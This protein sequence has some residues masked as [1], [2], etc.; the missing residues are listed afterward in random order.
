MIFNMDP[1]QTAAVMH[2]EGPALVLAGP[3]SGKTTVITNRAVRIAANKCEPSR[4]LCVTFTNAAAEEMRQR[5]LKLAETTIQDFAP[6]ASDI[7][8]FYTVHAFCNNIISEYEKRTGVR[9]VRI[10][11]EDSPRNSIF[12]RIYKKYN[13]S[14]PDEA[15]LERIKGYL[16]RE[17]EGT[18][19]SGE[20]IQK[21]PSGKNQIRRFSDIVREYT[22]VKKENG[23]IDFDDMVLMSL[24]LLTVNE[25]IRGWA[26]GLFDYIQV[27]EAQDL[28]RA[29][30][31]VLR[32]IAGNANIFIVADDDQS[33]YGFRG[34]EP[35]CLFDFA[36]EYP[37]AARYELTR[38]F[39]ST[40]EIVKAS[41][42]LVS[43]NKKRFF[44]D[45][46]TTADNS[47]GSFCTVFPHDAKSQAMLC[48]QEALASINAGE[49]LAVL[50]RNGVSSLPVRAALT[51]NGIK[52]ATSGNCPRAWEQLTVRDGFN[53]LLKAERK[54]RLIVPDPSTTFRRILRGGFAE[55]MEEQ[56]RL[57]G[58]DRKTV[59]VSMDFLGLVT[60]NSVSYDA[61]VRF[62]DSVERADNLSRTSGDNYLPS[63]MLSTI[64]SA[65]GL[66]YDRVIVIDVLEGE[67]PGSEAAGDAVEEERRLLYV[68]MTRAR[69]KL[70]ISCPLRRGMRGEEESRFVRELNP[71][72]DGSVSPEIELAH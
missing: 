43:V 50:Y 17:K 24:E 8:V 70:I 19:R 62:L 45:L 54:S 12:E 9:Y 22:R 10:E 52:Y 47:P 36:A 18:G 56:C 16:R 37:D 32:M 67:M 46:Y 66:E 20:E 69:R 68:A 21:A 27:D 7:P 71:A 61:A 42:A 28:S 15:M 60:D 4:L 23:Y 11:G 49:S 13:G 26:Q 48:A 34:A 39:R 6:D 72:G 29:Q 3:G 55:L 65:K 14:V 51:A 41:A 1:A 30:Y 38:N 57:E 33:I 59:S 53:E 2:D 64:H 25:E 44:K 5:Y 63:V 31:E 35:Q 40:P 58:H